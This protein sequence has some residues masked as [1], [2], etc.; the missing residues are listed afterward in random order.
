LLLAAG[1]D[2]VDGSSGAAGAFAGGDT[3]RRAENR[4]LERDGDLRRPDAR[5][6]FR[7]LGDLFIPG[8][9]GTNVADW[10][11]AVRAPTAGNISRG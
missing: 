7:A 2:G 10:V 5:R 1:S 4:V 6:L 11:F 3:L 8:P 9:T